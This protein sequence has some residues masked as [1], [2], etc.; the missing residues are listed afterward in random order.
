MD[1]ISASS[2]KISDI[3]SVI[4]SIAFQTNILALNAAVEAARA[5]EK[6]RGFAV[7]ASEVRG[8]AGRVRPTRRAKSRR[9]STTAPSRSGGRHARQPRGRQHRAAGAIGATGLQ[10]HGRDHRRHAGAKPAHHRSEPLRGVAGRND[11]AER[12]TGGGRRCRR[13][14]PQGPGGA[15]DA[16]GAHLPP[17]PRTRPGPGGRHLPQRPLQGQAPANQRIALPRS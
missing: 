1:A 4:D 7:V 6:G 15:P 5:G 12:C 3:T 17:H 2:R 16:D 11:A 10:H 9:S 8:L 13:R 14:K